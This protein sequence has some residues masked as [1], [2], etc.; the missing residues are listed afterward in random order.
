MRNG[1]K[2][3]TG[4]DPDTMKDSTM[5]YHEEAGVPVVNKLETTMSERM[6][7]AVWIVGGILALI[8]IFG[9]IVPMFV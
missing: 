8:L 1:L 4:I 9:V 6:G 5:K 2:N 7:A 3:I